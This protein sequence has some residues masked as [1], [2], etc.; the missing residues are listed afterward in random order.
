MRDSSGVLPPV[1]L[2]G[3]RVPKRGRLGA[4]IV[5][6]LFQ[7]GTIEIVGVSSLV[8]IYNLRSLALISHY[9]STNLVEG[10]AWA[11][12]SVH[13]IDDLILAL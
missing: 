9:C 12:S 4:E 2:V 7:E 5:P 8:N 13:K 3:T 1:R 10:V 6:W 11:L